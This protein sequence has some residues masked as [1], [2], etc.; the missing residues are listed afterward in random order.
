MHLTDAK[1]ETMKVGAFLNQLV[2]PLQVLQLE[3]ES[4]L[5]CSCR[6]S[7]SCCR[8]WTWVRT[9]LCP[10]FNEISFPHSFVLVPLQQTSGGPLVWCALYYV[11]IRPRCRRRCE[12]FLQVLMGGG[13]TRA[14]RS[15]TRKDIASWFPGVSLNGTQIDFPGCVCFRLR[16]W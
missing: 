16:R 1:W 3:Q 14:S 13:L 2:L 8:G 5:F 6:L 10:H 11:G 12:T 4:V 15:F 9:P 7:T